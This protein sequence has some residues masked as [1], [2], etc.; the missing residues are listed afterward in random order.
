MT[1]TAKSRLAHVVAFTVVFICA[2]GASAQPARD[3]SEDGQH[4]CVGR[5]IQPPAPQKII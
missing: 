3:H 4:G 1:G 5:R 2:T